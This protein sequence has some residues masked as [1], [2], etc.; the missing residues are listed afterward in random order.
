MDK[1]PK[2]KKVAQKKD[3]TNLQT[4]RPVI[5]T[6]KIIL[7]LLVVVIAYQL[8]SNWELLFN[9]KAPLEQ[10]QEETI[11]IDPISLEA[12]N[13]LNNLRNESG[14][15]RLNN[16]G[17]VYLAL[18]DIVNQREKGINTISTGPE[19]L[20]YVHEKVPGEDLTASY[21]FTIFIGG[22]GFGTFKNTL[23]RSLALKKILIDT[24]Y[25]KGAIG[26]SQTYCIIFVY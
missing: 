2:K 18:M 21:S 7:L 6:G 13:Y 22:G 26:C 8:I 11:K 10:N 20:K 23:D 14:V 24:R 9:K 5:S 1:D 16:P 4:K 17:E 15:S 12:M 25:T 19:I 3:Q